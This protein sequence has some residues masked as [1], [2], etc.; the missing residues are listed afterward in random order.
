VPVYGIRDGIRGENY[1]KQGTGTEKSGARALKGH[2]LGLR[3]T[4]VATEAVVEPQLHS[5]IETWISNTE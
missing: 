3:P 1:Y 2:F 4:H 5:D